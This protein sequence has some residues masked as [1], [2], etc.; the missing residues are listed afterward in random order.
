MSAWHEAHRNQAEQ[1]ETLQ[2]RAQ[3]LGGRLLVE[4][5]QRQALQD[6]LAMGVQELRAEHVPQWSTPEMEAKG[7]DP[8]GCLVCWPQDGHWPCA[9]KRV[10]DEMATVLNSV[11]QAQV[12]G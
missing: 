2:R 3:R 12:A 6:T 1:V 10:A 9:S 8:I 4:A 7:R 5:V 11:R